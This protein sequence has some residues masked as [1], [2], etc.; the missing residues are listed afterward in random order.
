MEMPVATLAPTSHWSELDGLRGYLALAVVALHFGISTFLTRALGLWPLPLGLAVDVFF[1]LSGFVLTHSLRKAPPWPRFAFKRVVR[2]VP[3]YLA[4]LALLLPISVLTPG[5][6]ALNLIVAS[7]WLGLDLLNFPAWSICWELYLP[8]LAYCLPIRIG[9]ALIRPML[10]FCLVA[11]GWCDVQVAGGAYFYPARAI[12]G[13]L[14][15]HLLFR[16]KLECGWRFQLTALPVLATIGIAGAWHLLAAVL[17]LLT[18]LALVSRKSGTGFFALPISNAIGAISYTVYLAHVPVLRAMQYA[19][20]GSVDHN[21]L[22]KLIGFG[23]TLV[24]ATIISLGIERPAMK[25]GA[26]RL[27]RSKYGA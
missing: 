1:M 18:A 19:W 8:V 13:L 23:A 24:L 5:E 16:S 11:L 27:H 9:D 2:L 25:W 12:L 7:P 14:A 26:D 6:V 20:P 22:V 15:G 17:P 10:V 3:V 4:T 21:P